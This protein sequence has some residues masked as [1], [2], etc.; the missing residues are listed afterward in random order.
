MRES[1]KVNI[2]MYENEI[3]RKI[4]STNMEYKSD[5][6]YNRELK[7]KKKKLMNNGFCKF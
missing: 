4:V 3:E 6:Y 5:K 2:K 1:V 7:K